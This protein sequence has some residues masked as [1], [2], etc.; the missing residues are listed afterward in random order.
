ME[1]PF[2][3]DLSNACRTTDLAKIP[4]LGPF[5]KALFGVLHYGYLSDSKRDDPLTKG[6]KVNNDQLGDLS[7]AFLLFRGALMNKEWIKDWV[8]EIGKDEI[9]L[10]GITITTRNLAAALEAAKLGRGH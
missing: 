2:Y 3:A 5:S 1:P 4:T 7:Q 10:N 9:K 6:Y 8:Q